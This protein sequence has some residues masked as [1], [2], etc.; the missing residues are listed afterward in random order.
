VNRAEAV[1]IDE[2][3]TADLPAITAILND[4]ILRTTAVWHEEPRTAA[5][6][7]EWFESKRRDRLP[8]LVARRG[9]TVAGYASYGPFRPWSGYARTVE[10]SVHVDAACRREGAGRALL[11]ALLARARAEGRHVMVGGIDA[12]NVASIAL[13]RTLGFDEAARMAEVGFKF[14]R[15]L[16]LVFMQKIL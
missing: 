5:Q 6:M 3:A 8:V 14:G 12:D 16:T 15:W 4:A 9:G 2:A 10:H 13:H 1:S 11:S 7:A